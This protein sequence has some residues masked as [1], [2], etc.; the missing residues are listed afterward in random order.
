MEKTVARSRVALSARSSL[1]YPM[2]RVKDRPASNLDEL[3]SLWQAGGAQPP[4]STN[5]SRR[6][7]CELD[8]CHFLSFVKIRHLNGTVHLCLRHYDSFITS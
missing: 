8:H 5:K 3:V 4:L 6:T 2:T 1:P 7:L